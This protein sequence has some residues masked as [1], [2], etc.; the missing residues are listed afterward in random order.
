L[1]IGAGQYQFVRPRPFESFLPEEFDLPAGRQVAQ[2][3]W[4]LVWR[5][6]FLTVLR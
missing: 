5:A 6:A 1:G 2:R 4:V 3:A